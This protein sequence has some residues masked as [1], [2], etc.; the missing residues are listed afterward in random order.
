MK[1]LN[2]FCLDEPEHFQNGFCSSKGYCGLS[3]RQVH[4]HSEMLIYVNPSNRYF[5]QNNVNFFC[6]VDQSLGISRTI[7]PFSVLPDC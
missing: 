1:E 5:T 7:R 6:A 4:K 2:L 3:V